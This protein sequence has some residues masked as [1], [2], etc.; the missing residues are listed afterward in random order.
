MRSARRPGNA[1]H[2]GRRDYHCENVTQAADKI[3]AKLPAVVVF[4]EAQQASV[5]DAPNNHTRQVYANTVHFS[6]GATIQCQPWIFARDL[7]DGAPSFEA[8]VV[9]RFLFALAFALVFVAGRLAAA[10][11]HPVFGGATLGLGA[12]AALAVFVEVD[13]HAVAAP[14]RP[15]ARVVYPK[16]AGRALARRLSLRD[17][18]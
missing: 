13:D 1:G 17:F 11:A 5:P 3:G 18:G 6:S 12:L 14:C 15:F 9:E 10:K 2:V 7:I 16:I 4:D 8:L